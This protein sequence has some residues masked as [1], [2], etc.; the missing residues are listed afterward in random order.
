MVSLAKL[1]ATIT[2]II[3]MSICLKSVYAFN[4]ALCDDVE[5]NNI[6]LTFTWKVKDPVKDKVGKFTLSDF[7]IYYKYIVNK[8]DI[9]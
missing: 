3:K 2:H 1:H 6:I 7:K 4:L 8:T 9:D 5:I